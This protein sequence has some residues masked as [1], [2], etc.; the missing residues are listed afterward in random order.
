MLHKTSYMRGFHVQAIDG[1]IGH[2]E[3]FL[4]DEGWAVR[5]LVVDTSN[6]LG[7][8]S[9]LIPSSA[10]EKVNSPDKKILIRLTRAEI[11]KS[12]SV[13]TADIALI[14]TLGTPFLV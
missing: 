7:G 11:E 8:K 1:G 6:W 4:V 13:D 14:E 10:V 12:P 3:D 5:F 2:V 9:V